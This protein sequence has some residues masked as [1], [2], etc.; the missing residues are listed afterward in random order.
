MNEITLGTLRRAFLIS[1]FPLLISVTGQVQAD[2][3][4]I[5]F[6]DGTVGNP[7]NAFYSSNHTTFSNAEW[8]F[9]S[10][11][12]AS[13]SDGLDIRSI[14]NGTAI[15]PTDPIVATFDISL[16]L[17]TILAVDVGELGAQLDVFDSVTGGNLLGSDSAFGVGGGVDNNLILSVSSAGIRR[18]ELYQPNRINLTQGDG[19]RFDNLT[20]QTIPEPSSLLFCA[21]CVIGAAGIRC[22]QR[23]RRLTGHNHGLQPSHK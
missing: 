22:A 3:V 18:I 10:G 11:A 15:P 7:I 9:F 6:N 1:V 2:L 4:T 23:R 12:G 8:Y 19:V 17:V 13:D 14:L 16:D 21:I 5:D 20:I